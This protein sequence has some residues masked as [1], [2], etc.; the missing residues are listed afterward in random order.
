MQTV[1][2]VVNNL[3]EQCSTQFGSSVC[4]RLN[5][6]HTTGVLEYCQL[7]SAEDGVERSQEILPAASTNWNAIMGM[8]IPRLVLQQFDNTVQDHQPLHLPLECFQKPKSLCCLGR[9]C[10]NMI[11][12][13]QRRIDRNAQ[14]AFNRQM[15]L[16]EC[17]CPYWVAR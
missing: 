3:S 8:Y 14:D 9:N 15:R 17:H 5:I 12:P 6:E 16:T 10:I 2:L 1:G 11:V 13:L 4:H 7:W